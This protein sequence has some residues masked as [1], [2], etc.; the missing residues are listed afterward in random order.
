[1]EILGENNPCSLQQDT[2]VL[3]HRLEAEKECRVENGQE[4]FLT[5]DSVLPYNLS[6]RRRQR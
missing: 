3:G 5:E 6:S 4:G 2:A 1:M